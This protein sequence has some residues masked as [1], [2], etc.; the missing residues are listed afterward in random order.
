MDEGHRLTELVLRETET[1]VTQ[2]YRKATD[3]VQK[4]LDDYLRRFKVK[5]ENKRNLLKEVK[6]TQDEYDYWR[7]GQIM[8]GKR[9]EEMKNT[10]AQ[11]LH[12]SNNIARS[13]INGH[14]PEV[15]RKSVV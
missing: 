4:K 3:E 10:L 2:V 9:W 15:D 7:T 1:D 8:V 6:I 13:I 11:D 5:D 12:N 14:M